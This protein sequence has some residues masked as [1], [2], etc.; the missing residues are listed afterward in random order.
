MEGF[1][2]RVATRDAPSRVDEA[3]P[4][5]PPNEGDETEG[6]QH[7]TVLP[8]VRC[9]AAARGAGGPEPVAG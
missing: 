3:R 7:A 1:L 5:Y 6:R 4:Y 2:M 8:W 9:R